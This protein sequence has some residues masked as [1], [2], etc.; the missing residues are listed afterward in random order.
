[1]STQ[2][3]NKNFTLLTLAGILIEFVLQIQ[4]VIVGWQIYEIKRNALYLGVIG[5]VEAVPAL[6]L[7]LWS[8]H[9]IDRANPLKVYKHVIRLMLF[10]ASLLLLV[11]YP[12]LIARQDHR[13]MGIY[14]AVFISGVARSFNSPSVHVLVPRLV[15]RESLAVSSAWTTS[16]IHFASILGPA[17]GGILYAVS[18]P[19]GPYSIDLVLLGLAFLFVLGIQYLHVP[20]SNENPEPMIRSVSTGLKYVF[21]HDFLL[22]ALALD[23]FAVL[24]GGAI[25]LL[26]IYADQILHVGPVG[27]GALR[28]APAAG[29]LLASAILIRFPVFRSAGKIL[30]WAVVGFGVCTIG[31]GVSTHFFLSLTLLGLLGAFDG[32]SMVI[33][34]AMVQLTSPDH[35]RGRIAAVN[36]IFIG[37]SNELGAFESGVTAKL[38]GTVPAVVMG[39]VL[40]LVIVAMAAI[41]SP[42]LRKLNMSE[43]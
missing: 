39:G 4:S 15:P 13:L 25:A 12:R 38:F 1:V 29:A 22:S 23:M 7:A 40:T 31:F 18:G 2:N 33:R 19:I 35:M 16:A 37:S 41:L 36:S 14:G 9:V 27:L 42:K 28:S 30:L 5:L 34:R 8:G 24:F 32:V 6:S 20:S 3:R 17:L 11:S 26:P 10:S 43:L 21:R